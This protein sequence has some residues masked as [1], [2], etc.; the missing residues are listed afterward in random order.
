MS[1]HGTSKQVYNKGV[2]GSGFNEHFCTYLQ[3]IDQS[4]N[5]N[6][7][8]CKSILWIELLNPILWILKLTIKV[9]IKLSMLS[10]QG[11]HRN[12][13]WMVE[14]GKD[15]Q[16]KPLSNIGLVYLIDVA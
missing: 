15:S 3:I 14:K 9:K 5:M 4:H 16:G 12:K 2:H 11:K 10:R 1:N 6:N 8:F 13:S 7:K